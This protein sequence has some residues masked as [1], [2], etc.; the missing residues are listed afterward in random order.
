MNM[1]NDQIFIFRRA[2]DFY[3]QRVRCDVTERLSGAL[4]VCGALQL[5]TFCIIRSSTCR[6]RESSERLFE[7]TGALASAAAREQEIY[8]LILLICC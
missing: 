6:G 3:P 7:Q 4:F 1:T 5:L 8:F 2:R